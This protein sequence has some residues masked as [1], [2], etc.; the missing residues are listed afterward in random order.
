MYT[1]QLANLDL[2]VLVIVKNFIIMIESNEKYTL[3]F[4]H[5]SGFV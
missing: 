2:F 3:L 4:F 1:V 5:V